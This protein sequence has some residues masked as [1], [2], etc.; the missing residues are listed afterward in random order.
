MK[1]RKG[2]E[3]ERGGRRRME[4]DGGVGAMEG[5]KW[6]RGEEEAGYLI[7]VGVVVTQHDGPARAVRLREFISSNPDSSSVESPSSGRTTTGAWGS[8]SGSASA[9]ATP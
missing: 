9:S 7:G 2:A 4:E 5:N 3:D 6:R 1:R 8:G